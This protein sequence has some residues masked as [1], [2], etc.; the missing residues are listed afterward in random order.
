MSGRPT[1]PGDTPAD[2]AAIVDVDRALAVLC[3][4]DPEAADHHAFHLRKEGFDVVIDADPASAAEAIIRDPR[5]GVIIL[6]IHIPGAPETL[7]SLRANPRATGNGI[8]VITHSQDLELLGAT[9]A[10]GA[11]DFLRPPFELVEFLARVKAVVRRTTLMIGVSP[12]TGLPGNQRTELEIDRWLVGGRPT[13][14]AHV[15]LDNFKPYNDHYGFKRGDQVIAFAANVLQNART[16]SADENCFVGHI[17]GDDFVTVIDPAHVEA[18]SRAV[19]DE[20]DAGIL[21]FYDRA[22]AI[23]GYI[24]VPDR[25]GDRHAFSVVSISLG[26]ATNVHRTL[27]SS[28]DASQVAAEM[29]EV[30]KGVPGS[31]YRIDRRRD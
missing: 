13:A 6:D 11:D 3:E 2:E 20:F 22:D 29:K 31:T 12:L 16:A 27:V 5:S 25:R 4:A 7:R 10:D 8:I 17:G 15:D 21:D 23:R 28:V 30:A 18:F 9:L 24:E 26:I 1:T 19:I 14:V